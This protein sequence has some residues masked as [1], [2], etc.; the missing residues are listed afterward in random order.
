[1][2]AARKKQ[3]AKAHKTKAGSSGSLQLR[4]ALTGDQ[5]LTENVIMEVLAAA[6]RVGLGPA[7]VEVFRKPRVGPKQSLARVR[8]SRAKQSRL[9]RPTPPGGKP[10]KTSKA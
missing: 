10:G 4:V 9:I 6:R 3:R 1:M 5:A 2:T 8:K 7:K